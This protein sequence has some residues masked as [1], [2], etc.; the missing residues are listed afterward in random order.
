MKNKITKE[1]GEKWKFLN[2]KYDGYIQE[3]FDTP[4]AVIITP[5]RL[6]ELKNLQ[7]EL[8]EMEE[9]LFEVCHNN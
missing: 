5:E 8:F 2:E 4:E 1:L 9:K 7:K 3:I 6:K